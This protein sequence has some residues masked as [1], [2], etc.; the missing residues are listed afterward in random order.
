MCPQ[1]HSGLHIT[2]FPVEIYNIKA[3]VMENTGKGY[4]GWNIY[5][6]RKA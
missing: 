5:I 4:T 6:P 3:C 2:V 1:L